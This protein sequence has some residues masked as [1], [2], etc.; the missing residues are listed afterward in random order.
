MRSL[1]QQSRVDQLADLRRDVRRRDV[2]VIGDGLHGHLAVAFEMPDRE[3][4]GE[5]GRA[6]INGASD[7]PAQ[8]PHD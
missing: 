5:F 8:D 3:Q 1:G 4:H 6:Q 2:Q 7:L